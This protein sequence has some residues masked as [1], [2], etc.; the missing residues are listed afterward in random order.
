MPAAA[1]VSRLRLRIRSPGRGAWI[2]T[3]TVAIGVTAAAV[4]VIA[5]LRGMAAPGSTTGTVFGILAAV[6]LA[7]V[8][9]YA[10]RRAMPAVRSLGRTRL[11]L[12]VHVYVGLL[13]LL[14]M[15]L[16]T[17]F[18]IPR[19]T[20]VTVVW[21]LS[22]WVVASG[23]AGLWLQRA[24]PRVLDATSSFE[25]NLQRI[26][27]LVTELRGRAE[28]LATRSGP[29]VQAYYS[30]EL[31]PDMDA[32]RSMLRSVLGRS[33]IT[34][35]RAQEFQI[36]RRTLGA[37][38][39]SNLDELFQLHSTKLEMDVHYTLQRILRAWLTLHVPASIVLLGLVVLHIFFALYY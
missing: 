10:V 28:G 18:G 23:L 26:P 31:A 35:Y 3:A 24:V 37:D 32:P 7:V 25:V 33:R 6:A 16:H 12:Q 22:L 19:G 5:R 15:L 34:S 9:A 17:G 2:P 36:L 27:E 4:W 39:V 30:R 20:L 29:S 38:A 11:Y 8:M 14:L 21:I 1:L 13:F